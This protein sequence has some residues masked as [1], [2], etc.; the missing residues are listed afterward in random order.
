MSQELVQNR[1]KIFGYGPD[2]G[3]DSLTG[4]AGFG[5]DVE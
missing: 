1:A 4:D 5:T 2:T 3:L